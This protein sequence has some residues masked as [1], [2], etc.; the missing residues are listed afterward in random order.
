MDPR[1]R[2]GAG[3]GV[4]G[5]KRRWVR[6]RRGLYGIYDWLTGAMGRRLWRARGGPRVSTHLSLGRAGGSSREGEVNGG[7]PAWGEEDDDFACGAGREGVL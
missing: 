6:L 1:V 3:G 4:E 2:A 7:P 5:G